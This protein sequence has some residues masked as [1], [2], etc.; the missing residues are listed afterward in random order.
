MLMTKGLDFRP[1]GLD[2]KPSGLDFKP[3]GLDFKPSG[4]DFKPSGLDFRPSG[5]DFTSIV[6]VDDDEGPRFQEEGPENT[7]GAFR[8]RS[9]YFECFLDRCGQ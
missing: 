3:S 2:F 4:L 9:W 8:R 6:I 7:H 1:G 5:L